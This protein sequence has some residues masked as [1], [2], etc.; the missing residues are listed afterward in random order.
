MSSRRY[1]FSNPLYR[2]F[3]F[4]GS[5]AYDSAAMI[6]SEARVG[7]RS[8]IILGTGMVWFDLHTMVVVATVLTCKQNKK[9]IYKSTPHLPLT[10]IFVH[11]QRL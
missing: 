11:L 8:S 6:T 1:F 4:R 7:R 2:L 9:E 10:Y 5:S 3:P